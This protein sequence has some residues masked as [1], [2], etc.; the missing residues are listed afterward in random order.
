MYFLLFNKITDALDAIEKC[1]YGAAADIL[2]SAQAEAEEL[3]VGSKNKER[4]DSAGL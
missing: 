3:Y 4:P 1:N 2:M